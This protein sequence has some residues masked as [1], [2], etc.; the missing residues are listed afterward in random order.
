MIRCEI[1]KGDGGI[2]FSG[3]APELLTDLS[4]I[5]GTIYHQLLGT[6]PHCAD[7]F[8]DILTDPVE[9]NDLF[10]QALRRFFEETSEAC[11]DCDEFENCYDDE[12][13]NEEDETE[14]ESFEEFI[15]R[16]MK[17]NKNKNVTNMNNNKGLYGFDKNILSYDKN[18]KGR[19]KR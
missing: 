1:E 13:F 14:E 7:L 11:E 6:C 19:R 3:D 9:M 5:I 18:K 4:A 15:D 10:N 16:Y 17:D 12:D 8:R 2:E